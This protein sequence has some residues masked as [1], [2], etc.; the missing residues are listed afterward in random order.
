ME[1]VGRPGDAADLALEVVDLSIKVG[2]IT[3][4]KGKGGSG[5]TT[6]LK[7]IQGDI[8]PTSGR[9]T[10]GGVST[11]E[12]NFQ[13]IRPCIAYVGAAPVMFSGTIGIQPGKARFRAKDVA[14]AGPGNNDQSATGRI[15]NGAWPGN[16]RRPADVYRPTGQHRPCFDE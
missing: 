13:A 1:H 6:L 16:W 8:E 14:T 2:T 15:R 12:P 10:I 11:M 7:L 3:G 4:V 5:R 9:V